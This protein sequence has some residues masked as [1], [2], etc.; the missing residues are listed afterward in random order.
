MVQDKNT[1]KMIRISDI[2][3][4]EDYERLG[5]TQI[6]K[7]LWIKREFDE[8]YRLLL[9][10]RYKTFLVY[11]TSFVQRSFR[12]NSIKAEPNKVL[13]SLSKNWSVKKIPWC[14]YGFWIDGD[15]R[16][17]GNSLEHQLG[18]IYVQE[19]ASMIPPIVLNPKPGEIVLDM[20][21]APGSK[22]TQMA[23]MMDNKGLI[24]ANEISSQRINVLGFNLQRCG[25]FNTIVT[26]YNGMTFPKV[27]FDKILLDAPCSGI[28]TVRKSPRTLLMWNPKAVSKLTSVQKKL[29]SHAFELLKV[30]GVMVYSTCSMEPEENEGVVSYLLE[31][32]SNARVVDFDLNVERSEP[33]VEFNGSQYNDAVKRCLRIY[34]NDNNT[35][36]F[37]VAKITKDFDKGQ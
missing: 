13:Q 30:G 16:D 4:D 37:F 29:I 8:R 34:P 36:G 35:D 20:S 10:E 23:A 9:G 31:R 11:L 1:A 2:V 25:V 21:A 27:E 32:Y 3:E 12:I 15:R 28:G 33:V 26:K 7:D 22:T 17:I 18:L 19:A 6:N 5:L 14:R 24:V